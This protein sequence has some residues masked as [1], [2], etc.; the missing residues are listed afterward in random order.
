MLDG[1][2]LLGWVAMRTLLELNDVPPLRADFDKAEQ[3]ILDIA[4]GKLDEVAEIA[5]RLCALQ[6][7]HA[8]G[9][10]TMGRIW[11]R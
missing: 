4:S 5:K 8:A 6:T 7:G 9:A 2:K 10:W 1:N 11:C 3:F